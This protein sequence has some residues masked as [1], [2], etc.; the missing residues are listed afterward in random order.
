MQY[1]INR[2]DEKLRA[3]VFVPAILIIIALL[4]INIVDRF[5]LDGLLGISW[6]E[7]LCVIILIWLVF[8][9]VFTLDHGD[10]H[11]KVQ[12]IKL[13]NGVQGVLDDLSMSLFLGFLVW[14]TWSLMPRMFSKY[15]ALGWPIKVGYYAI[16]V[17]GSIAIL[18][19]L[20]KYSA[21]AIGK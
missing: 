12:V 14:N 20:A 8:L 13:P 17:G 19:K 5:V 3:L 6:V 10:L 9:C 1:W 15:A 21:K 16:I 7:E 4:S 11:I 18:V 2:F